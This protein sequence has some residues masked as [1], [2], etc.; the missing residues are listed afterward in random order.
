MDFKKWVKSIQTA[1][2][3]GA[4]TVYGVGSIMSLLESV[5]TEGFPIHILALLSFELMTAQLGN[6]DSRTVFLLN[7]KDKIYVLLLC[8]RMLERN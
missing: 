5:T 1:G 7:K 4:R 3:N 6:V 2:Y 8:A